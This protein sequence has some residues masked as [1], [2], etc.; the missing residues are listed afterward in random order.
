MRKLLIIISLIFSGIS[1]V[2]AQE[3]NTEGAKQQVASKKANRKK[4]RAEAKQARKDKKA[5]DK[6]V[7]AHHERIQSKATLQRMKKNKKRDKRRNNK[8]L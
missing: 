4:E 2:K 1:V 7:K 8:T 5:Y 6:A 3:G